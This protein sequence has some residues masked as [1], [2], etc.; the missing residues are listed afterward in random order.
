[1]LFSFITPWYY[2]GYAFAAYILF[3]LIVV[4]SIYIWQKRS[5]NNL[6]KELLQDQ[7]DRSKAS[8]QDQVREETVNELLEEKNHLKAVIRS[9]TIEMATISKELE[10]KKEL[11][12]TLKEKTEALQSNP[13]SLNSRL[14]EIKRLLDASESHIDHTFE[15]QMDELHQELFKKLKASFPELTNNDLRLCAYINNGFNSKEIADLFNIKPSS[16]YISRSRLR[17]KLN[18][19][20]DEDLYGFLQKI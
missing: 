14:A 11:L 3:V 10:E 8:E 7:E 1:M 19:Q 2:S 9:K 12:E 16:V 15:M 6:R 20:P 4:Y 5:F 17:K 13:E 18:L